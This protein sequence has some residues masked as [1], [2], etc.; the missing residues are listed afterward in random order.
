M[1]MNLNLLSYKI[2]S[3]RGRERER[4]K[5]EERKKKRKEKERR[6]KKEEKEDGDSLPQKSSSLSI[7][8]EDKN[9]PWC[10]LKI[11]PSYF[12]LCLSIFFFL[13]IGEIEKKGRKRKR[14]RE[15]MEKGNF[16]EQETWVEKDG[17]LF[18]SSF[19]PLLIFFSLSLCFFF[20]RWFFSLISCQFFPPIQD[21][22]NERKWQ[23]EKKPVE[24]KRERREIE[25]EK[26][27]EINISCLFWPRRMGKIYHLNS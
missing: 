5:K 1:R 4:K 19:A 15:Q 10:S 2:S 12:P 13:R 11:F 8:L 26:E 27:E 9:T 22:S 3:L 16:W 23:E 17:H 24:W 21:S 18:R 6:K 25:K 7:I 14:W 20:F